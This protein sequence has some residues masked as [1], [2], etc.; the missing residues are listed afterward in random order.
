MLVVVAR[1]K[2]GILRRVVSTVIGR[3]QLGRVALV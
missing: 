2:I 1:G 3:T